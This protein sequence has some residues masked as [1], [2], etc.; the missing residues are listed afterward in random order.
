MVESK[1]NDEWLPQTTQYPFSCSR[2]SFIFIA[3]MLI[4][5]V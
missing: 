1:R 5:P 4:D 2:L 3:L